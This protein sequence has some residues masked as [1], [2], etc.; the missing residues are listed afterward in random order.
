MVCNQL[1]FLWNGRFVAT[2]CVMMRFDICTLPFVECELAMEEMFLIIFA[3][4]CLLLVYVCVWLCDVRE[5][6]HLSLN[7]RKANATHQ[8]RK[9]LHFVLIFLS[10]FR[11]CLYS[12]MGDVGMN[13]HD[14]GF[15]GKM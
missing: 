15:P 12:I 5:A 6:I 9:K 8:S 11:L 13:L 14:Y 2:Y 10:A 7:D 4:S 3:S 1:H